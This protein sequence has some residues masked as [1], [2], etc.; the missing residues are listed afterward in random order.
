MKPHKQSEINQLKK[1]RREDEKMEKK[2]NG[3]D[4]NPVMVIPKRERKVKTMSKAGAR[5]GGKF[6]VRVSL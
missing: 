1:Q 4:R 3:L 5:K 2:S 6:Y